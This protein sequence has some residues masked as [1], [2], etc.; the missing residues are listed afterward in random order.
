MKALGLIVLGVA[1]D[2]VVAACL[3]Q[4]WTWYAVPLGAPHVLTLQMFGLKL[5]V[6]LIRG[7]KT[8]GPDK[9]VEQMVAHVFTVSL[10]ALVLLGCGWLGVLLGAPQ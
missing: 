3:A 10:T 1:G 8:D 6:P 7:F 4:L 5:M 9:T 2:F